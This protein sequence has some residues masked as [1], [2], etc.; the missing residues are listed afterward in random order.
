MNSQT[1]KIKFAGRLAVVAAAITVFSTGAFAGAFDE[2]TTLAQT[3][4][5]ISG[6]YFEGS[7]ASQ[8]T[9]VIVAP[10]NIVAIRKSMDAT[11]PMMPP[12]SILPGKKVQNPYNAANPV[13]ILPSEPMHIL[14]YN[15]VK[16]SKKTASHILPWGEATPVPG[17]AI[18]SKKLKK[19]SN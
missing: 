14:P 4:Q 10:K 16:H 9:D 11:L 3:G 2:L 17:F 18:N 5:A 8:A 12:P 13:H 1:I 7:A 19:L 15:G 6:G